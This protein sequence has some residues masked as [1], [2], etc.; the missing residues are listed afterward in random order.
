VPEINAAGASLLY[1]AINPVVG[2]TTFLAN[3]L[4]RGPLV[5]ANTQEFLIDGS[6]SDPHV[7]Q[8]ERKP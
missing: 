6:W 8:V 7:T 3:L 4:L 1:S 2:L 5:N